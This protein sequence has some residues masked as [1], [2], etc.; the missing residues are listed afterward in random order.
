MTGQRVWTRTRYEPNTSLYQ[1]CV[2]TA[3]GLLDPI[4]HTQKAGL[5]LLWLHYCHS[6]LVLVPIPVM[7]CSLFR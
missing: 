7:G 3:R 2:A 4:D 5:V 1:G 6:I